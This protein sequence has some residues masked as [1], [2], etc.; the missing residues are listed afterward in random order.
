VDFTGTYEVVSSPDFDYG[1][2]SL[3]AQPY[4]ILRQTGDRVTG[5]YQVGLQAGSVYGTVPEGANFFTFSFEGNGMG[6][7]TLNGDSLT[8]E[9]GITPATSSRSTASAGGDGAYSTP[10][11]RSMRLRF[12]R[13]AARTESR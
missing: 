8:F 6:E 3:D 2:L 12:R 7:A 1:Y 11:R 5:E 13:W 4:V 9:L 10:S